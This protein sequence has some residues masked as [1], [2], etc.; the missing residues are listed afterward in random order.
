MEVEL[1]Y[2]H[3]MER[4]FEPRRL[5]SAWQQVKANDGAAGIDQMTVGEFEQR[6]SE[7]LALI[8]DKLKGGTYRFKPARRTLI[9]KEGTD[10]RPET[11]ALE[12]MRELGSPWMQ[13]PIVLGLHDYEQYYRDIFRKSFVQAH[14]H[15]DLIPLFV[16]YWRRMAVKD[17]DYQ[18]AL[19]GLAAGIAQVDNVRIDMRQTSSDAA[20]CL[21]RHGWEEKPCIPEDE[22]GA[23]QVERI[24]TEFDE[25]EE[26]KL[27]FPKRFGLAAGKEK[28]H[29]LNSSGTND[30]SRPQ[31][32]RQKL[33]DLRER[34][35]TFGLIPWLLGWSLTRLGNKIRHLSQKTHVGLGE[36]SAMR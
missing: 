4:V 18:V 14:K 19:W 32:R 34:V 27:L 17:S 16:K 15:T 28:P 25:A 6:E 11:Y 5:Q 36:T 35:G 26:Y 8:H 30:A 1:K 33:L 2:K 12:Q 10:L 13:I 9:P 22:F 21:S 24:I 31:S 20:E 29:A 3:I 23:E 7:L